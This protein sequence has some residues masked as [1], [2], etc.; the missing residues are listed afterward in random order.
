MFSSLLI[1]MSRLY[2]SISV[3]ILLEKIANLAD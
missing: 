1:N 3:T 2:L